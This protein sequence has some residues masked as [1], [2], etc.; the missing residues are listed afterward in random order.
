MFT[1]KFKTEAECDFNHLSNWQKFILRHSHPLNLAFHFV[2]FLMFYGGLLLHI[3]TGNQWWLA[4]FLLSGRVGAIGH[5]ISGEGEVTWIE[6]T[7]DIRVPFY[8][9]LIFYRIARGT[10]FAEVN[11]LREN[12]DYYKTMKDLEVISTPPP[13]PVENQ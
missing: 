12:L 7:I 9:T 6:G 3:L 4:A 10:Y 13:N 8:V 5:L 11:R 2:S 1:A